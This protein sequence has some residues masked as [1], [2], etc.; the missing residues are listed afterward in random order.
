[1][2]PFA[3]LL[4][5]A[6]TLLAEGI[7]WEKDLDAARAAAGKEGKLVLCFVLLGDL[8]AKDC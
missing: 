1:M 8:D 3:A 2:K 6:S 5:A 4:L 7:P